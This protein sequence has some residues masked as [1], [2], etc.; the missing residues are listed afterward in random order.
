MEHIIV[1]IDVVS[2]ATALGNTTFD[3]SVLRDQNK[4][5]VQFM[6]DFP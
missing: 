2:V 1:E 4:N 6:F 5:D 3:R